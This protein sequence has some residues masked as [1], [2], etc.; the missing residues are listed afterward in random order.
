M[1]KHKWLLQFTT[2]EKGIATAKDCKK[3]RTFSQKCLQKLTPDFWTKCVSFYLDGVGF[4]HKYK[5]MEDAKSSGSHDWPKHNEGLSITAKG[6][7]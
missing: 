4:T 5:P 3:R 2:K 7:K 6:K 1:L